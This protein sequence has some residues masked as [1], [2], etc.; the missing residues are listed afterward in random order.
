MLPPLLVFDSATDRLA[1]AVIA[2]DRVQ[3]ADEAADER[4]S[5]RLLRVIAR[6]L[7]AAGVRIDDLAGIGFGRGPGAFTGLRAACTVAQGLAL[8]RS[9]PV[10]PLD[11]LAVVAE[12]ARLRAERAHPGAAIDDV[13]VVQDARMGELYAAR[14]RLRP[15]GWEAVEPPALH[16]PDTWNELQALDPAPVVAGSALAAFGPR[17]QPGSAWLGAQAAPGAQA[18][19]ACMRQA[20]LAGLRG[21]VADALPLYVRDKVAE[22]RAERDARRL[23]PAA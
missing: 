9:L 14:W 16:T 10:C 19:A 18:L 15:Q 23:L 1:V 8:A 22:T 7:D 5:S 13:R 12:D 21:T 4:A 11:T 2:H 20:W 6:L 17:L 3:L